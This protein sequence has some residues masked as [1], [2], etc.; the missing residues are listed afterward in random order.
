MLLCKTLSL[1]A[2]NAPLYNL[3]TVRAFIIIRPPALK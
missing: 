3:G 1:K 2:E